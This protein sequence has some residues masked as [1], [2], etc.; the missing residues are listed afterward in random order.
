MLTIFLCQPYYLSFRPS[1]S[2]RRN[3]K[4]DKTSSKEISPCAHY[5]RLVE[6]T[7]RNRG[8]FN[9]EALRELA[10]E[11]VSYSKTEG[12]CRNIAS[13]TKGGALTEQSEVKA[14]GL[15]SPP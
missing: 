1:V 13:L 6:M 14:M 4:V 12:L 15:Q 7:D 10:C 5:I 9:A 11:S 2:E 8:A 3:L